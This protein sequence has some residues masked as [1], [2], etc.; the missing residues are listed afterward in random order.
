MKM[1]KWDAMAVMSLLR[2]SCIFFMKKGSSLV[3]VGSSLRKSQNGWWQAM[4]EDDA[5]VGSLWQNFGHS[6]KECFF[7]YLQGPVFH[8]KGPLIQLP[9]LPRSGILLEVTRWTVLQ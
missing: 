6:V 8:Q 2:T 9:L 1:T 7:Q 3:L 4:L 5:K